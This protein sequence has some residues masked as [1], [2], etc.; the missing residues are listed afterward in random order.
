MQVKWK[1][2]RRRASEEMAAKSRRS[3]SYTRT[4]TRCWRCVELL[5]SRDGCWAR[6]MVMSTPLA[7]ARILADRALP[8]GPRSFPVLI[9]PGSRL[10]RRLGRPPARIARV[11][12]MYRPLMRACMRTCVRAAVPSCHPQGPRFILT[13]RTPSGRPTHLGRNI[14]VS[15]CKCVSA[16]C[17]VCNVRTYVCGHRVCAC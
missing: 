1:Q 2:R 9:Q 5:V 12:Q 17:G 13:W 11:L 6:G 4:R 7:P 15:P 8:R 16:I 14:C 10:P 3:C